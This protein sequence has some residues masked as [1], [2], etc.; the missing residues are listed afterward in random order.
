M[1]TYTGVTNFCIYVAVLTLSIGAKI[2]NDADFQFLEPSPSLTQCDGGV[3][4]AMTGGIDL[5]SLLVS[6]L[7]RLLMNDQCGTASFGSMDT[8][9]KLLLSSDCDC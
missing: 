3:T 1:S 8:C 6:I 7:N 4:D 9:T 5:S 2:E